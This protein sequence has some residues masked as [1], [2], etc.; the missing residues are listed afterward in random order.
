MHGHGDALRG[1]AVSPDGETLAIATGGAS[2]LFFDARTYAQIG[3][4]LPVMNSGDASLAYSP[5]GRALAIGGDH[6]VRVIDARTRARLAGTAV[7]GVATRLA[8][9]NDGSQLVVLVAPA[10]SVQS[11]GDGNAQITIRDAGTLKQVRP[12]I[13][14]EAFVGAYVGVWWASPEFALTADDRSLITASESGE[15]AWW[16]LRTGRKTRTLRIEPGLHALAVSPDGRTAA[17]GIEHGVRLVDLRSG[18]ARTATAD[19]AG[20][21][22]WVL[23]SPDGKTVVSTNRD[24]TV[25]RWDVASATP[26]ETLR[27]H[28]NFVQ[29]PTF[30]PDGET[31]YTVSH[32]GTA[33]AWDLPATAR[34][35]GGSRS[36]TIGG[37]PR[38]AL[39]ATPGG[40]ALTAG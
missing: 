34:S 17:V 11:L 5:D 16:D 15:L 35:D 19:L 10:S 7:A 29:Q 31:L 18:S 23:F 8:F 37:S 6:F 36:H 20:S 26:L 38:P 13:G 3:N 1:I 24:K 27:G 32:D 40:S 12:S 14:P 4:P 28:S 22:N 39:T 30:S 25:T 9:T 2:L 21:P 33:I